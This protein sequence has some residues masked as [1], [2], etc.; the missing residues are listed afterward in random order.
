MMSTSPIAVSACLL[1]Y[2]SAYD[3]KSRLDL[4]L[5]RRLRGRVLIPVCPEVQGGM[6]TPRIP[7]EIQNGSERV[8]DRSGNDVSLCFH[9]GAEATLKLMKESGSTMAVLKDGSPSCGSRTIHDGTFSGKKISGA[10]ITCR[11]LRENG[12]KVLDEGE[13]QLRS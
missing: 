7:S 11:R 10:G 8:C 12:I 2:A 6:P 3:G 4:D 9:K 5:I 1:G 13:N